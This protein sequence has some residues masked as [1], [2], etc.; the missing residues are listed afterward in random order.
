MPF[1]TIYRCVRCRKKYRPLDAA[2]QRF[3]CCGGPLE[4]ESAGEWRGEK[5]VRSDLRRRLVRSTPSI[6]AIEIIPPRE[7]WVD[8]LAV[9]TLLASLAA[10]SLISLE[11]AGDANRRRFLGR[12]SREMLGRLKRKVQSVYD[13]VSFKELLPDEDPAEVA[14]DAAR[15]HLHVATARMTLRRPAYLPLRTYRD[16]DFREADPVRGLLGAFGDFE[17]GECALSQVILSPAPPHWADR[18]QGSTRRIDQSFAGEAMTFETLI[19]QFITVGAFMSTL[20]LGLCA[21][22]SVMQ[23]AWLSLALVAPFF[24]AALVGMSFLY[25]FIIDRTKVDP[26]LVQSKVA[27]PACDVDLRIMAIGKTPE[28]AI[29]RLREVV[30]AYRQFNLSSGNA[31]VARRALFDPRELTMERRNPYQELFGRMMRLNVAELAALWHLPVGPGGPLL[32]R[33]MTKRLL[34]VPT[35][36]SEGI[37][38]GH[39]MSQGQDIPVHLA[40]ETLWHHVFMVAKTQKGKSTL[41]ANLAAAAM[42]M[43]I[44][45]TVIDPHGDLARSV[46]GLVPKTRVGDV[47]YIDFSDAQ[48]FVGLN[49][50]DMAQGRNADAIVSN[51]VHVGEL[52]WSDFWGP[53][54][55]DALRMALRTL[56]AANEILARQRQNQ[57][58]LVDIPSLYELPNF[59]HRIL[60]QYVRDPEILQWWGGYFERL[61]ESLRIDVINPVLTK[62]HR[63]S[64]HSV[65]RNI[66]SQ[67]SSTVNFRELLD[68]RR[69]LVVNTATG[70]IGPDAGGLLGAV[71]V[72]YVNF[73]VRDQMAI[74]DRSARARVVVIIDEFQSI[75]GVD[76]PGLLAELQKMG[77]SFILATQAL[78]QLDAMSRILRPAILSNVETLFVFQTSAE[79]ADILRHEL[80]DEVNAIDITNLPDYSSYLKTKVGRDRLPVMHIETLPPLSEDRGVAEQILTQ[81]TR[82]TRPARRVESERRA[83][84]EQ[85]YGR[86]MS[87]LRQLTMLKDDL[88]SEPNRAEKR[89]G[90]ATSVGGSDSLPAGPGPASQSVPET[91]KRFAPPALPLVKRQGSSK[92]KASDDNSI[93]P[94]LSVRPSLSSNG[95]RIALT[96]REQVQS[97]GAGESPSSEHTAR[98]FKHSHHADGA[99]STDPVDPK[100]NR[101]AA[102]DDFAQKTTSGPR[103]INP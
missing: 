62:I 36:V 63:F 103:R 96:A 93:D 43:D 85:W 56:L 80:D 46:L 24:A 65:V 58:T 101:P 51:I 38:V 6:E 53:R 67:S 75:P 4:R 52:I 89:D 9:E 48:Q 49:L 8:S 29:A 7:N 77:A 94:N 69:I 41:M 19:R 61:Y 68:R 15:N 10:E 35:N 92:A 26:T 47:L 23:R 73:A 39:S 44:A 90:A 14:V 95:E 45:L 40:L 27:T 59:R 11:I 79:D 66:V 22:F 32:Q 71:L 91:S 54:M 82:Y 20:A 60:K 84:Q 5:D 76:Y 25:T 55:E 81:M 97:E 50:L 86:E 57:F 102:P 21:F 1:D 13:Q 98:E 83:F 3:F 72:D 18:Y 42:K 12:A 64:T 16:G 87:L 74:P 99:A 28:R 88:T 70:V 2:A 100:R 37:L 33:N 31:L 34:P 30:G 17:K 78:G